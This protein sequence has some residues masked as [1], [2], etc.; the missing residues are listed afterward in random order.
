[1]QPPK[2]QR[3]DRS[4]FNFVAYLFCSLDCPAR[5]VTSLANC[6][7]SLFLPAFLAKLQIDCVRKLLFAHP[8]IST[9]ISTGESDTTEVVRDNCLVV[10]NELHSR[11]SIRWGDHANALT[12]GVYSPSGRFPI[13]TA[14]EIQFNVKMPYP[15]FFICPTFVGYSSHTN[16][17]VR[18]YLP[19]P[20]LA[21]YLQSTFESQFQEAFE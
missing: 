20:Q 21:L 3:I 5:I 9:F 14:V 1:M 10:D 13:D 19:L 7:P 2:R 12:V 17:P 15:K 11:S 18:Q 6:C 8:N 4:T 16:Y